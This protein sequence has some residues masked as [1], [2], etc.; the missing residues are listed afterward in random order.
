MHVTYKMIHFKAS[1]PAE[2]NLVH[3]KV[4]QTLKVFQKCNESWI[5]AL[6]HHRVW[7]S[8]MHSIC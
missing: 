7:T 1:G 6:L 5:N 2:V 8:I 3:H 4:I